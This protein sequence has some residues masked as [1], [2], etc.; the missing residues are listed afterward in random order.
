MTEPTEST[1]LCHG[2]DVSRYDERVDWSVLAAGG[3]SFMIAKAT[4]GDYNRDPLLES[5][6]T[7][8]ANAGLV[9]GVYHW[10]D[11]IQSDSDQLDFLVNSIHGLPY[12]FVCLDV[13]QHWANWADWPKPR[14]GKKNKGRLS[15]EKISRNAWNLA[16]GLRQ[17]LPA[18]MPV[19]IYTRV[20]FIHE[21][22][23][24]MLNWLANFPLWMAQ[25]P[26]L[27]G[28]GPSIQWSDL[29][30]LLKKCLRPTLPRGSSRW[31]FWQWSGDRFNLPGISSHPD[32]NVFAGSRAELDS[33][34]PSIAQKAG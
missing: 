33:L 28:V 29:D 16:D 22:A 2:I 21:Y 15:P 5:H 3:V 13:E 34:A 10:C 18:G 23:R 11:P 27:R 24:P 14:R 9:T 8:A 26:L 7:G 12:R 31:T 32:L 17:Q 30:G 20:S 1:P 6:L 4:Q 25:Y 19:V